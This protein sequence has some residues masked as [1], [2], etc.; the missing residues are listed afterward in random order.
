MRLG[1]SDSR[2]LSEALCDA[3]NLSE[4]EQLLSFELNRSLATISLG[5]NFAQVVFE[6]IQAANRQSWVDQLILAAR[7][8]NPANEKLFVAAQAAGLAPATPAPLNLEKIVR[9]GGFFLDVTAW[10]SRLAELEGKICRLELPTEAGTHYGTGFLVA[11]GVVMTNYHVIEP[12]IQQQA[13]GDSAVESSAATAV[14]LRFDYKATGDGATVYQGNVYRLAPYDWLIDASPYDQL[15]LVSNLPVSPRPADHLDYA[16]LRLDGTPGAEPIDGAT[17]PG[18]PSRGSIAL[19]GD[20][21]GLVVGQPLFIL[22]HPNAAPL[23]L[24]FATESVLSLNQNRTRVRYATNTLG[25][26]SGSPC[27]DADWNLVALHHSGDP[28]WQ[29]GDR[30]DYNQGIPMAAI[31]RLLDLRG[32]LALLPPT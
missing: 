28:R 12:L 22:Q 25:G 24:A 18:A 3:F 2:L 26:S 7:R 16:L 27:F 6:L 19:P 1:G 14:R 21:D 8:V 29:E 32:K 15:D 9:Q 23:K 31:R 4:L 5:R 10:R 20:N 11:D 13:T 17:V 30:G